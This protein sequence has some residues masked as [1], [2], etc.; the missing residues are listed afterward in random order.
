MLVIYFFK[1]LF[2]LYKWEIL[3]QLLRTEFPSVVHELT[4]LADWLQTHCRNPPASA[5]L[6]LR[7]QVHLSYLAA[8]WKFSQ[9]KFICILWPSFQKLQWKS[10][11]LRNIETNFGKTSEKKTL[12]KIHQ[13][14]ISVLRKYQVLSVNKNIF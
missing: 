11:L 2:S 13:S 8:K 7:L 9:Q 1:A 5:F 14:M 3:C 6:V 10:Q 12:Q 4:V